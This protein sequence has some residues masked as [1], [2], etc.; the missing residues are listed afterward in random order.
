MFTILTFTVVIPGVMLAIIDQNCTIND[1][2][3]DRKFAP[4]AINCPNVLSDTTCSTLYQQAV[5]LNNGRDRDDRCFKRNGAVEP[6]LVEAAVNTC[7][8]TC[9]YCCITPAYK[10]ENNQR[11]RLP[12]NLVTTT[13]CNNPTWR[14]ILVD[15]CPKTC[16]L[17]DRS[18]GSTNTSTAGKHVDSV[19]VQLPGLRYRARL[20]ADH[21]RIVSNG[22]GT[23][24]VRV[25]STLNL[26]KFSIV[27]EYADC[28]EKN[29][30]K[31][32]HLFFLY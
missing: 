16:G 25:S 32:T 24:S 19:K 14:T 31:I 1:A 21:I 11:P 8:Q 28:V 17:C 5:Q 20:Y 6:E 3:G 26:K 13:M 29:F 7:P 12:C 2:R 15:D 9:G 27:V 22:S 4:E 10:C 23:D 30:R 18:G